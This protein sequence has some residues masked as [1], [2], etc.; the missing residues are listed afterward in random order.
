MTS[1]SPIV[2]LCGNFCKKFGT[3]LLLAL[4]TAAI[5]IEIYGGL[6]AHARLEKSRVASSDNRVWSIAQF[7]VDYLNL[8]LALSELTM[9]QGAAC[10]RATPI[11]DVRPLIAPLSTAFDIFYSRIEVVANI[12]HKLDV[13]EDLRAKM[14]VLIQHR[15]QLADLLDNSNLCDPAQLL[16]F[17]AGVKPMGDLVRSVVLGALANFVTEASTARE[18]ETKTTERFFA[19]SIVLLSIMGIAI[20]ISILLHLRLARQVSE[21]NAQNAHIRLVHEASMTAV[22]VTSSNGEIQML[23]SAAEH[24]F[25]YT[26][27]ETKGRNI[28][29]VMTPHDRLEKHRQEMKRYHDTGEGA[30]V[31]KG[32]KRTTSLR[33]D[34][35]EIP[36]EVSIRSETNVDGE[37]VLIAFF[38]DI[39]DQL[40]Y[41]KNLQE[42]RDEAQKHATAKTMFLATMSHE[43][44]TPL[45]GMLASLDLIEISDVDCKTQDLIKTARSCGLQTLHQMNDVLELTRIEE[46]PERLAAFSPKRAA[47]QIVDELRPLAKDKGNQLLLNVTGADVDAEWLG[48]PQMFVRA[49]YNLVGNALKFTQDG[50]VSI[51]LN[52]EVQSGANSKLCVSVK[53]TGRGI[54]P[55]DQ[56]RL[57]DLFFSAD[58]GRMGANP[59]G[60]GLGLPIAQGAV[61]KMGGTIVVE[62]QLGVGST[63]SFEIPLRALVDYQTQV[64]QY[65]NT[66]P[67]LSANLRCLV[68]DDNH[69]NLDLTAQ[70]L[71]RLGCHVGTSDSGET[72]VTSTAEQVFDIVFMDL[73]M[74]GGISGTEATH[75][76]RAQEIV[77][78]AIRSPI[79]LALTADTTATA[80]TLAQGLFDG[81]LHKPVQMQELKQALGQFMRCETL[82][83]RPGDPGMET[84][85][86]LPSIVFS[87]LFDLIGEEHGARL[88]DG[89]LGDVEAALDAIHFRRADT[90]DHLHRAIGSTAAVGLLE[91]SQQLRR[92]EDLAKT[93]AWHALSALVPSLELNAHRARECI[94]SKRSLARTVSLH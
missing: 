40:A 91:F 54:S 46:I 33:H 39:S 86:E 90:A 42:A 10:S 44:R 7:E 51:E 89:V 66:M 24:L 70:M 4:L 85:S 29:D 12:V 3:L 80:S 78:A 49:M 52:F 15:N 94:L 64:V 27:I 88:L 61:E 31:D 43:M 84:M 58:A 53:D 67:V 1:W 32:I 72:A 25:G 48:Y 9:Q 18:Q 13:P 22:V 36:V 87:D 79:I 26:E 8:E 55:G 45:H 30:F 6:E 17:K 76:I 75:L 35:V 23:N 74:P 65:S 83:T 93:G 2:K 11:S 28:A 41:E 62:S 59:G 73:N 5:A 77:H 21:I 20:W 69:V 81:I 47:S 68:V 37:K 60:S 92:A 34:G 38:R 50:S 56:A 19:V 16:A 82:D 63:F 57:F 71:R 14:T